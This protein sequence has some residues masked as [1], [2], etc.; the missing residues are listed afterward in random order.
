MRARIWRIFVNTIAAASL[1]VC[2]LS[3]VLWL[4]SYWRVDWVTYY[5]SDPSGYQTWGGGIASVSGRFTWHGGLYW[6]WP[7]GPSDR[8][9][10]EVDYSVQRTSDLGIHP[11]AD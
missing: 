6:M 9:N 2:L 5:D 3:A 10:R 7:P 8:Q 11:I 1:I 4:R